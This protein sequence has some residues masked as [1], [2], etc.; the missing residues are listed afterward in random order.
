LVPQ[1]GEDEG[2]DHH[3]T[4]GVFEDAGERVTAVSDR[5]W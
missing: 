4:D 1:R 5:F 2:A 3:Q